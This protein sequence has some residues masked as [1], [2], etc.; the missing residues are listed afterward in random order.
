MA[1]GD[2]NQYDGT[3]NQ[4]DDKDRTNPWA[5]EANVIYLKG[6]ERITGFIRTAWSY[7][8]DT[9]AG[10]LTITPILGNE[11]PVPRYYK[12][13]VMDKSGNEAYG[14]LDVQ[15]ETDD[16]VID[17]SGL[18]AQ[19][20]WTI[21]F[22]AQLVDADATSGQTGDYVDYNVKVVP[23]VGFISYPKVNV[24]PAPANL[25][26]TPGNDSASLNWDDVTTDVVGETVTYNVYRGTASGG[27]YTLVTNVETSAYNNTGL[28]NATTYYFVVTA[29]GLAGESAQSEEDNALTT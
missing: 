20:D 10:E 27:P 4:Y 17:I 26:A 15:N 28:A 14:A 11:N 25:V 6:V 2:L 9:A 13:V 24:L 21:Y 29:V 22:S 8:I 1:R 18:N 19:D 23:T 12:F 3:A 16:I 5:N 7:S